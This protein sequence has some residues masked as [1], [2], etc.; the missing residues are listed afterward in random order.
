MKNLLK[1]TTFLAILAIWLWSTAFAVVKIGLQYQSPLQFAGLRFIIAGLLVFIAFGRWRMILH[2]SWSNRRFVFTIAL[3]QVIGQYALFYLGMNLI[4][5][6]LGAMLVGSSPLFIAMV[7]HFTMK[8]DRLSPLKV[9]SI[10]VGVGGIA[11][12]TLGRQK[13]E[14]RGELEWLGILLLLLNNVLS[15][16]SNVLISKSNK[17]IHPVILSSSSLITGGAALVLISLPVEGISFGPFPLH[18]YLSLGWLGFLSA[19]AFSIWYTLLSRPGVKVSVLNTWKFLIP[20]SG[21]WLSWTLI[22]EEKPDM[23]QIIAMAVI[24][25]SLVLLNRA[26]RKVKA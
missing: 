1:S 23:T 18:Y 22:P 12:I 13:M 11:I 4:P 26:N 19:A 5:S 9:I 16:Y 7:A 8:N 15:G 17:Q 6:A 20:V 10:L 3:L 2:E 24:A 21:A 14:F 25:L